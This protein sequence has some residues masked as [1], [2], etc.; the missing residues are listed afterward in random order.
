MKKYYNIMLGELMLCLFLFGCFLVLTYFVVNLCYE[1]FKED[2][3]D[4]LLPE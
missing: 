3:D 2:D 4:I 1:F